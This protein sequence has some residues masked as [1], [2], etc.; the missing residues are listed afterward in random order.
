[1]SISLV[2][3][4]ER[5]EKYLSRL[6]L[7]VKVFFSTQDQERATLLL[8]ANL[9]KSNHER[10]SVRAFLKHNLHMLSRKIVERT[11]VSGE[12]DI[13]QTTKEYWQRFFSAVG[14]GVLTAFTNLGKFAVSKSNP[15]PFFEGLFSWINY[16]GSF[17]TMQM[18]HFTLATKQPSMKASALASHLKEGSNPQEFSLLVARIFRS[19]FISALGNIGAVIPSALIIFW[20]QKH[21]SEEKFYQ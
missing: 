4:L 3:R 8:L 18:L 6:E 21:F 2:Y 1:V 5:M 16:S 12:H 15:A 7:L 11:G 14:G 9:V 10:R 19:Q 17:L 20:I 13:T